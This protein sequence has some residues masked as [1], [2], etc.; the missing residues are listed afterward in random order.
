MPRRSYPDSFKRDAVDLV[1]EGTTVEQVAQELD[2]PNGTVWHWVEDA[3]VANPGSTLGDTV[4][5]EAPARAE[6]R[7][8]RKRIAELEEEVA[9]LGKVTAYFAKK[10]R[11]R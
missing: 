8:A 3:G 1:R 4:G 10:E 5:L 2:V 6:L 9:F 11:H 7:T